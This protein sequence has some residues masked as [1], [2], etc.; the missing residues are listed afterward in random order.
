MDEKNIIKCKRINLTKSSRRKNESDM[1][2]YQ[3]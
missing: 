3:I 2:K 1:I